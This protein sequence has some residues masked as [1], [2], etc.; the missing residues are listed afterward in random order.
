MELMSTMA[1]EAL[2]SR[3]GYQQVERIMDNRGGVPV[4]LVR[5]SKSL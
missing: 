4:P 5:M 2:Y 3:F 1:G